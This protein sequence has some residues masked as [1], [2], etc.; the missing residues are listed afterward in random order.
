MIG[1][2]ENGL[3][4]RATAFLLFYD[5]SIYVLIRTMVEQLDTG[6]EL[7]GSH[8]RL[9]PRNAFMKRCVFNDN[10]PR[11]DY[12]FRSVL[13]DYTETH[14]CYAKRKHNIFHSHMRK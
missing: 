3:K 4:V 13:P 8:L 2:R 10:A 6:K 1:N 5:L 9:R 7:N 11:P 14:D 12:R